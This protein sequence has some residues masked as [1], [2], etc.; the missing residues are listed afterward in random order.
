MYNAWRTITDGA[1]VL[2][3]RG[4]RKLE[5]GDHKGALVDFDEALRLM[6]PINVDYNKGSDVGYNK[7]YNE[8]RETMLT[9]RGD[10]K[11]Q[12]GDLKGALIDLDAALQLEPNDA[13]ALRLRGDTKRQLGN[14]KGALVDLNA[15]LKH[16]NN[17]DGLNM[18]FPIVMQAAW[19]GKV[20]HIHLTI[21]I[22]YAKK[23]Y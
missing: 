16:K 21:K 13:G 10:A 20:L 17:A 22:L 12:L 8:Y 9:S 3:N 5:S 19:E 15:S 18:V 1:F 7:K 14:Y 23:A 11:R 6:P 2:N 4:F